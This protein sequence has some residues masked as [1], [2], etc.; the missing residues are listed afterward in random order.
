MEAAMHTWP[1]AHFVTTEARAAPASVRCYASLKDP[2]KPFGAICNRAKTAADVRQVNAALTCRGRKL[3]TCDRVAHYIIENMS[4][5][6][7]HEAS[8]VHSA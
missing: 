8:H 4:Q 5:Q 6:P 2:S 7:V 1:E 3:R